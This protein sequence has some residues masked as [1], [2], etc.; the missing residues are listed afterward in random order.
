MPWLHGPDSDDVIARYILSNTVPFCGESTYYR[1]ISCT[2][3]QSFAGFLIDRQDKLLN[4]SQMSGEMRRLDARV[5]P[6]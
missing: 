3:D 2:K 5:I 1:W 4:N 6:P